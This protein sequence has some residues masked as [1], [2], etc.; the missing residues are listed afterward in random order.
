MTVAHELG[1]LLGREHDEVVGS[2]M[3]PVFSDLAGLPQPCRTAR[4]RAASRR[5]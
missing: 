1:H 2:V 5:R 4:P 3:V